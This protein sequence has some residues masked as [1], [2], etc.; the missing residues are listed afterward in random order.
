MHCEYV[1]LRN[2]PVMRQWPRYRS[3]V[4]VCKSANYFTTRVLRK[5]DL[6]VCMP[7]CEP[8]TS[9]VGFNPR[10]KDGSTTRCK[11]IAPL[12]DAPL[13]MASGQAKSQH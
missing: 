5:E 8:I 7:R 9:K 3:G 4:L 12:C 1:R 13:S 6:L 10:R 11:V 2:F